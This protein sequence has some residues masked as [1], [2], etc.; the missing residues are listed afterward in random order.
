MTPKGSR[1]DSGRSSQIA[2]AGLKQ[3]LAAQNR[4]RPDRR[5][6]LREARRTFVALSRRVGI[7]A[8]VMLALWGLPVGGARL[9][10][11]VVKSRYF[12]IS[13]VEIAGNARVSR[14]EIEAT[15]GLS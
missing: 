10:T 4:R 2:T 6:Q 7:T 12:A 14:A 15:L 5:A 8:L 1:R 13:S 3:R 9:W 11:L